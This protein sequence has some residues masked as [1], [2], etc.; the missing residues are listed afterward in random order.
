MVSIIDQN[1]CLSDRYALLQ[2]PQKQHGK[3]RRS[4]RK[5]PNMEE[6]V[7]PGIDGSVQP[8]TCIIHLDHRLVDYDVIRRRVAGRP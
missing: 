8:A 6:F 1:R 4:G 7:R 5:E 3:S 2:F